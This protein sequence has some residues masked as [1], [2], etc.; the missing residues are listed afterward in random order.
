MTAKYPFLKKLLGSNSNRYN[1]LL[2]NG[3]IPNIARPRL[4]LLKAFAAAG[5]LNNPTKS[6]MLN[7]QFCTYTATGHHVGLW[8]IDLNQY[9][10]NNASGVYIIW[11]QTNF[12][13][14][15]TVR[16]GQGRIKDRFSSYRSDY[17][18]LNLNNRN[19]F[20]A[21]ASV[22]PPLQD[23]IEKYLGDT[24]KPLIADRFPTALPIKVNLPW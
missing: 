16:V 18:F 13:G 12:F 11:Y 17:R 22:I 1:D 23:G 8:N 20:T 24:L 6:L 5:A 3:L 4:D 21:W 10:F 15:M 14:P 19:L 2:P 9:Y 7:W